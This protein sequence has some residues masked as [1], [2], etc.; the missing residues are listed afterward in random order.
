MNWLI[1]FAPPQNSPLVP[2]L[3]PESG[4]IMPAD[5]LPMRQEGFLGHFENW[6]SLRSLSIHC[7]PGG[8][9]TPKSLLTRALALLPSLKHLHLC[10]LP[11]NA[12]TDENLLCLPPLHT[13]T[14]SH[15]PG[16]SSN[17]LSAFATRSNSSALRTL[18]LRHT[19]LTS[20]PALARILSNLK[21]L[22]A[23]SL[24]QAFPPLMPEADS[25]T[26]WMMPYLASSNVTKLH[27]DITSQESSVNAADDILARSIASGGISQLAIPSDAE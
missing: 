22:T 24:V 4:S 23:F 18:Q 19:P 14:L 9:V 10:N 17:G 7:L 8:T 5:L 25:F 12:F 13:L 20:L 3:A 2:Q 16:I 27:W 1:D 6:G 21:S 11:Q 15:I 26:L